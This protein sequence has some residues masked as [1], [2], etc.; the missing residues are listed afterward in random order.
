[1][2][3]FVIRPAGGAPIDGF[4]DQFVTELLGRQN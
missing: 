1:L 3:K 2:T 4:I